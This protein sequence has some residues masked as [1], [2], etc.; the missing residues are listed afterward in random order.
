MDLRDGS[1][2]YSLLIDG[3]RL[4]LDTYTIEQ[5]KG[6]ALDFQMRMEKMMCSRHKTYRR[7]RQK[8]AQKSNPPSIVHTMN[9]IAMG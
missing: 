6:N 9:G 4:L 7:A 5:G 1:C 2:Y 3:R 8:P